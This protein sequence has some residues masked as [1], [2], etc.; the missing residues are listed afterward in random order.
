[1]A[2]NQFLKGSPTASLGQVDEFSVAP[3]TCGS[4]SKR[5]MVSCHTFLDTVGTHL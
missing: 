2:H 3:F 5:I 1:M 4:V